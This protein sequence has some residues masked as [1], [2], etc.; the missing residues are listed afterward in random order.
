MAN[1]KKEEIEQQVAVAKV[2]EADKKVEEIKAKKA[3]DK[4]KKHEERVAKHPK[5]GKAINWMDDHKWQIAGGV[6]TGGVSFAAGW[7]GHKFFSSKKDEAAAV[8]AIDI[9]PDEGDTN[10][11]PFEA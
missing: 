8:A 5:L 10:E 4:A 11:P 2:V 1:T 6:A 9:T 7:F 3:A